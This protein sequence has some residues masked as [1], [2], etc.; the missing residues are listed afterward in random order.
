MPKP[1]KRSKPVKRLPRNPTTTDTTGY[2]I[3]DTIPP[4]ADLSLGASWTTKER[5]CLRALE[6]GQSFVFTDPLLVKPVT[7]MMYNETRIS[8]RVFTKRRLPSGD[9]WRVWR[10]N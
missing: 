9:G 5:R 8:G 3:T 4:P 7:T 10:V 1:V 2:V 6:V